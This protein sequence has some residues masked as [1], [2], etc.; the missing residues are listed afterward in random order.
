[1]SSILRQAGKLKPKDL[2]E[3]IRR[4]RL[5]RQR[6]LREQEALRALTASPEESNNPRT[7]I[8]DG[9]DTQPP[10][11]STAECVDNAVRRR[12]RSRSGTVDVA[13]AG[14]MSGA[15]AIDCEWVNQVCDASGGD[16]AV[17]CR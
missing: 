10:D 9:H 6:Q 3:A 2:K 16:G 13:A 14:A 15:A 1:M 4:S 5:D 17:G 8:L 11:G 12:R 7:S